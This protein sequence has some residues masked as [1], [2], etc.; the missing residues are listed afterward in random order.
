MF[1]GTHRN[2]ALWTLLVLLNASWSSVVIALEDPTQPPSYHLSSAKKSLRLESILFSDSRRVAVINGKVFSEGESIGN[3][4]VIKIDR[5][6]V[7][8]MRGGK[9][10]RLELKRVSIRQEK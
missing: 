2:M 10:A 8:I 1:S 6:S 3:T 4:K 7:K 9:M 5:D